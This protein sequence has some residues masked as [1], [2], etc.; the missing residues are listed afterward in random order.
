MTPVTVEQNDFDAEREGKVRS[1]ISRSNRSA[2][3]L[4]FHSKPK[5]LSWETAVIAAH[6]LTV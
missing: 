4:R 2:I 1:I 3:L 5:D 6:Y